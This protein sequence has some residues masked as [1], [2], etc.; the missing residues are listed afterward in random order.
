MVEAPEVRSRTPEQ[1]LRTEWTSVP[2]E[3]GGTD[4]HLFESGFTGPKD[5]RRN[6]GRLGRQVIPSLRKHLGEA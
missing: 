6:G 3:D 4:L 5:S 1:V 2:R